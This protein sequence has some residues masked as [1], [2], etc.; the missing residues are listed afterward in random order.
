MSLA[1]VRGR[2]G[3][4]LPA[5]RAAGARRGRAGMQLGEARFRIAVA[6]ALVPV[7]LTP[8][9]QRLARCAGR[10]RVRATVGG[11]AAEFVLRAR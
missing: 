10:L 2:C 7:Q 9:A 8:R 6:P 4:A 5:A 3:C 11:R 1:R